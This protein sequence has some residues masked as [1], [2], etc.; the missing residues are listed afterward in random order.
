MKMIVISGS[1]GAGKTTVMAEASD[2][3]SANGIAHA[4]IDADTLGI[5]FLPGTDAADVMYR[6]LAA[7]WGN[8]AAA[9]VDR[10]LLAEALERRAELERI[11]MALPGAEITVCRLTADVETM[12]RRI[13]VR[14]PGLLQEQWLARVA[15]L[16]TA[17]DEAQTMTFRSTTT[18]AL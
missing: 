2:L 4:A 3:L 12:R 1:L 9:G 16:N 14:E 5:V 10:L 13:R 18:D 7:V 17:L 11:R 6:N 15:E 8:C